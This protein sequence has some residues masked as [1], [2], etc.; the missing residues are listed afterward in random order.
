MVLFRNGM[1]PTI[2]PV[3]RIAPE[4]DQLA[5][6]ASLLA[7]AQRPMI[8]IGDGV[9]ASGAQAE[10]THVAEQLG[11]EVWGTESSEVYMDTMLSK[12]LP[13]HMHIFSAHSRI[14]PSQADVV[15]I[16]GAYVFPE[17]FPALSH[18]FASS[19]NIIHIDLNSYEVGKNVPITPELISDPRAT[20]AR[21]TAMLDTV[22]TTKQKADA[23]TR[24]SRIIRHSPPRVATT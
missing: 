8:I 22:M 17:V 12:D 4:T 23:A 18:V 10:L 16:C 13:G 1:V 15:L 5:H 21:L 3:I 24:T 9:I 14:T 6:A 2:F 19:A 20:L 7:V 11:A